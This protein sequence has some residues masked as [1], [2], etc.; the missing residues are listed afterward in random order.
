MNVVEQVDG[1]GRVELV[2]IAKDINISIH[3]L[4][5]IALALKGV[6]NSVSISIQKKTKKNLENVKIKLPPPDTFKNLV[7]EVLVG[8]WPQPCIPLIRRDYPQPYSEMVFE[9]I[10]GES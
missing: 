8:L 3:H 7:E 4:E 6:V 1:K 5:K 10:E 9:S 2:H